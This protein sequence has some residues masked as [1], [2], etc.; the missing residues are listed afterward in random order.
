MESRISNEMSNI[1]QC[2]LSAICEMNVPQNSRV[3]QYV[4][5]ALEKKDDKVNEV[6]S[7]FKNPH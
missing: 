3:L 2:T 1:E 4:L 6:F 7:H 5:S